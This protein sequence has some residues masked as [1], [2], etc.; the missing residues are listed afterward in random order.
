MGLFIGLSNIQMNV[1]VTERIAIGPSLGY[2][3]VSSG[4]AKAFLLAAGIDDEIRLS[5]PAYTS[6]IILNPSLAHGSAYAELP[7]AS[8]FILRSESGLSATCDHRIRLSMGE[9]FELE[10]RR[11]LD[12][13][14]RQPQSSR[15]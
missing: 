15:C 12:L 3:N 7:V 4:S 9:W 10:C 2:M 14:C 11:R 13:C 6:R 5:A 8:G 1:Q